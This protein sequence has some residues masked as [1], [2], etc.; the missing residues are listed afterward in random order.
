MAVA[1]SAEQETRNFIGSSHKLLID[2]EWVEA[3]SGETFA[4]VNPATEE[5][6][7]EVGTGRQRTST[8]PCRRRDGRSRTTRHGGA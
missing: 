2:G 8:A 4:S 1:V 3:A 7:A 6:L 5:T